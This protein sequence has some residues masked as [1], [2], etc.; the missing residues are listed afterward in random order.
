[1]EET[2]QKCSRVRINAVFMSIEARRHLEIVGL[3]NG[4]RESQV[5]SDLA[6]A[7]R[8]VDSDNYFLALHQLKTM[9]SPI[10]GK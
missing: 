6:E 7:F 9:S 8:G 4:K 3:K 10:N 2:F 1:M 5:L